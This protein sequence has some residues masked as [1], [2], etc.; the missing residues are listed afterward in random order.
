[1][2][3]KLALAR[4]VL[5]EYFD[6]REFTCSL[7]AYEGGTCGAGWDG[8]EDVYISKEKL[9]Y[10]LRSEVDNEELFEGMDI[11]YFDIDEFNASLE[12][13]ASDNAW[14]EEESV[15]AR[16]NDD[17]P[18]ELKGLADYIESPECDTEEA[19]RRILAIGGGNYT[20]DCNIEQ[21]D[22]VHKNNVDIE[23]E[24]SKEEAIKL[25]YSA[26]YNKGCFEGICNE[27]I[28]KYDLGDRLTS[29]LDTSEYGSTWTYS[30]ECEE[31][32]ESISEW[33]DF[34]NDI[35]SGKIDSKD[36]EDLEDIEEIMP[37]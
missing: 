36:L 33:A 20:F 5:E 15:Y 19:R 16:S 27:G 24:L 22:W 37:Y 21:G 4:K 8:S 2:D 12:R 10:L 7:S 11:E 18:K 34:I 32:G 25:L 30:G 1:M 17:L 23:I 14:C 29:T 3:E 13:M 6:G 35:L 9:L 26:V 31:L 28:D